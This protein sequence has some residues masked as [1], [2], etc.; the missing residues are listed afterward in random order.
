MQQR[1]DIGSAI[2]NTPLSPEFPRP[3]NPSRETKSGPNIACFFAEFR[4]GTDN[5][6]PA[7]NPS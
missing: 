5:G 7:P 6:C 2:G 4:Y 1:F 3:L